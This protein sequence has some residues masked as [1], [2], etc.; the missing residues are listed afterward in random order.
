MT[1]TKPLKLII[2][3]ITP[4]LVGGIG[5]LVTVSS[6]G[7]WYQS[8]NKPFFTPPSWVF[9]PAW[10]ILY[11]L[12]GIALFLV[13]NSHHP[14]KK[15]AMGIFLVQLALNG[16]WSPVFFGLESPVIGL[17]VIVPL[18]IMIL[19]CIRIF[20]LIHKTASYLMVPYLL[21]VSFATLLNASIWYLNN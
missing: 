18:W 20:F 6:I 17:L 21:W 15:T 4:Q 5:A 14:L 9:G 12:M 8:I 13:W 19:V 10:T 11:L 16:L 1:M 3:L 7:S 2:S